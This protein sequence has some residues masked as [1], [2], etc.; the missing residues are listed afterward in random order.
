[1]KQERKSLSKD[2]L[3]WKNF[4]EDTKTFIENTSEQDSNCEQNGKCLKELS[5]LIRKIKRSLTGKKKKSSCVRKMEIQTGSLWP[6]LEA[7]P[8]LTDPHDPSPLGRWETTEDAF[9]TPLGRGSVKKRFG[10]CCVGFFL[11]KEPFVYCD[12]LCLPQPVGYLFFLLLSS[13]R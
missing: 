12:K 3:Q 11:N 2:P 5:E 10:C 4:A 8:V 6:C 13:R 9:L 1:M 7:T